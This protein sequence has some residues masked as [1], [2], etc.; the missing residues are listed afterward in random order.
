MSRAGK[1]RRPFDHTVI[2]L[3]HD[4]LMIGRYPIIRRLG[5]GNMGEVWLGTHPDLDVLVAI[6]TL[7]MFLVA[8][9]STYARRL[10]REARTAAKVDSKHVVK[11]HDSGSAKDVHFLVM[12]YVDGGTVLEL[13]DKEGG[14][15]A[16]DRALQIA[17]GVAEGLK[18]AG[19]FGVVHRDIK[20]DNIMLDSSGTPKLGDLGLA[21]QIKEVGATT[22]SSGTSTTGV[23][24]GT[25]SYMAP[26]QAQDSA[27]VDPRAD[28]YSLGVTLYHMVTGHL[29]Y[30]ASTP[31]GVLIKHA[32]RPLPHPKCRKPDLPDNV[33]A[34]ICKMLEKD[35]ADRYQ[36]AAELLE[37]LY[38]IHYGDAPVEKL[39]AANTTGN[40]TMEPD[41]TGPLDPQEEFA[42]LR[43]LK[44][45]RALWPFAVAAGF[46]V[47]LLAGLLTLLGLAAVREGASSEGEVGAQPTGPPG[48]QSAALPG[49]PGAP[50][51]KTDG[52]GP[53]PLDRPELGGDW[54]IPGLGMVFRAI[55]AGDFEMGSEE[56]VEQGDSARHAVRLARPFWLGSVEVTQ[57]WFGAFTEASECETTAEREGWVA[58]YDYGRSEWVRREG[59][60]W[61][62]VFPGKDRPAV[63][64]S[65]SDSSAF[66]AWLTARER[67][68]GR[69]PEGYLYRLPTEAEWE[70]CCRAG[71]PAGEPGPEQLQ[72]QAWFSANSARETHRVGTRVPNDWGLHDMRGNVREWCHDWHAP[73]AVAAATDP[74]GPDNGTHRVVRGGCWGSSPASCR[75][76]HRFR[77]V[78]SFAVFN[79]GFRVALAPALE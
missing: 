24:M 9:D 66:C 47:L 32:R 62:D 74:R 20:P 54:T 26:E 51:E 2:A 12:E 65:W 1:Q 35:P 13:M 64:V 39:R 30:V 45:R 11:I 10:E 17:V 53:R 7:P 29:P 44:R 70:Y 58:S 14:C 78:P 71:A 48:Q 43:A 61:R 37:D 21:K 57:A 8:D 73:Y 40:V 77:F 28:I 67:S 19:E 46:L 42:V 16:A 56:P 68:A 15:L 59:A 31:V 63:C 41:D 25:P 3:H 60:C 18:A 50:K 6:K 79:L 27:K 69:L 23:L 72:R 52:P 22:I 5:K 38:R 75:S 33:C 55:P 34:V 4:G 36:S 49:R 76:T